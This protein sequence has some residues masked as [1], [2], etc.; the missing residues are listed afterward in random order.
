MC[1]C[2]PCGILASRSGRPLPFSMR[3]HICL[4]PALDKQLNEMDGEINMAVAGK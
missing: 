3:S 4:D 1:V 2:V